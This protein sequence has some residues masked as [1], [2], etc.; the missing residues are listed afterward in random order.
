MAGDSGGRV[1][2]P[3]DRRELSSRFGVEALGCRPPGLP[4]GCNRPWTSLGPTLC[5]PSPLPTGPLPMGSPC[6]VPGGEGEDEPP[7]TPL[8]T[9]IPIPIP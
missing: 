1:E 5:S 9:P 3:W 4:S 8:A 7:P 2:D 6:D